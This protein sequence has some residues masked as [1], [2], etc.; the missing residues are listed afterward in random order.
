[1]TKIKKYKLLATT[2]LTISAFSYQGSACAGW[3][4][5]DKE[6]KKEVETNKKA[7]NKSSVKESSMKDSDL[8][9][10]YEGGKVLYKDAK[11]ALEILSMNIEAFDQ[12]NFEDLSKDFKEVV[13][14][15][16]IA[17]RVLEKEFETSKLDKDENYIKAL[18]ILKTQTL[19]SAYLSKFENIEE[20]T[21]EFDKQKLHDNS[22]YL[23]QLYEFKKNLLSSNYIK[24]NA[25]T[26][27]EIKEL[28]D[29][30]KKE[31]DGK[32]QISV[33][34]I[35]VKDKKTANK[36]EKEL[37][38]D[39]SN[40]AEL[41]KKYSEDTSSKANGGLLPPFIRGAKLKEFESAAFSL[42]KVGSVSAPVK[43]KNGWHIIMLEEKTKFKT[44]SLDDMKD[45]LKA[46]LE[47]QAAF[48]YLESISRSQMEN[49]D[50]TF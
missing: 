2:I 47:R 37:K 29:K 22:L 23:R 48:K 26:D 32:D 42:R 4:S 12:K 17:S 44:A 30:I 46:E 7:N 13:I 41:A 28:H 10:T 11:K 8:L 27:K 49:I 21:K 43:T 35:F 25:I 34:H 5:S 9:A 45:Q 39:N 19:A 1:M 33:R 31:H 15:F 14:K 18:N 24:N 6:E 40:F 20:I 38:A 36:I 3:F 50:Y 16:V